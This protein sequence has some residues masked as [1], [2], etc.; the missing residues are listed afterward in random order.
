MRSNNYTYYRYTLLFLLFFLTNSVS[1]QQ[2]IYLKN[3]SL[4]PQ[5][6]GTSIIAD[7]W[8]SDAP[9]PVVGPDFTRDADIPASDGRYFIELYSLYDRNSYSTPPG[10]I[11][12][13][14]HSIGQQL[15]ETLYTGR[16]YSLSFDLKTSTSDPYPNLNRPF[17]GSMVIMGSRAKGA[18][19]TQVYAS[20]KFS[21]ADWKQYEAVFTPTSD[22][23]YIRITSVS[24]DGDTANVVTDIDNLSPISETLEVVVTTG[25]SCPGA[26]TGFA[27]AEIPNPIDTYT[28]LWMPGNYTTSVVT[29]LAAGTYKLTIR[30]AT[31]STAIRDVTVA[32]Y[33]IAATATVTGISCYG[34]TDGAIAIAATGGQSPYTYQ[35]DDGPVT[36][37][38]NYSELSRGQ[39][40]IKVTDQLCSIDVQVTMPEPE[41]LNIQ[42]VQ[43]KPVTCNNAA[44]GQIVLTATG[45]TAPY[46]YEVHSGTSQA[47]SIIGKLDEGSY[48]YTVTDRHNCSVSGVAVITREWSNCGVYVPTAFSPNGDGMNDIFRVKLQDD[49]TAYYI[50]V[51]GRWGELVYE[52]RDPYAVWDGRFKET[53]LPA[54]TYVW[55]VTYTDSKN[56]QLQQKGTLVLVR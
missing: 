46:T 21:H 42:A 2:I 27:R 4:D 34:K 40:N 26:A 56:Q 10:Q 24:L 20:G 37:T 19:E 41:Q 8:D 32:A 25:K 39:Y 29:G 52:S 11:E 51:Y 5:T 13:W 6:P 18:P 53:P 54:G 43:T 44:N 23:N 3:P 1:A 48:Q 36:G 28:Y 47:D 31:G 7:K 16:T 22:I 33:D 30:G 12:F 55:T 17:Y 9:Y 35:L 49:V 14:S 15:D 50:A 38:G 45:G